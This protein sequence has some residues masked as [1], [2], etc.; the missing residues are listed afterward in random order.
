MGEGIL[1][2]LLR[3]SILQEEGRVK[4]KEKLLEGIEFVES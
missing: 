1:P 4:A 2:K 3:H